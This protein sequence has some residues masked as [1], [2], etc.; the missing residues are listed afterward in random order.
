MH[1]SQVYTFSAVYLHMS[2][3]DYM[4]ELPLKCIFETGRWTALPCIIRVNILCNLYLNF[5]ILI[6]DLMF[7]VEQVEEEFC[8]VWGIFLGGGSWR[9]G[10]DMK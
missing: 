9:L 10:C 3:S 2:P 7:M 1:P 6:G 4:S 5:K 8:F